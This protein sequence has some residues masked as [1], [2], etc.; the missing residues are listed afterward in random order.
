M[1][2]QQ[3]IERIRHV[4]SHRTRAIRSWSSCKSFPTMRLACNG[5]GERAYRLTASMRFAQVQSRALVQTVRYEP[6]APVVD[7][8]CVRP[9]PASHSGH[10]LSQIVHVAASLVLC[11]VHDHKH[12][13]RHLREA[14]RPRTGRYVQD[15]L[16]HLQ[17]NPVLALR[18]RS[19][20]SG[21][22]RRNGRDA[23]RRQG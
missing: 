15:G 18:E 6:T 7:M 5:S 23:N 16:A 20:A 21:R 9:S 11:D 8:R 19:H 13:L 10:N 14:A 17:S 22:T 3:E 1:E 2:W 12:P 4:A